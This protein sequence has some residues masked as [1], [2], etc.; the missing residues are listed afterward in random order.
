MI[1]INNTSINPSDVIWNGT[2]L[3]RL[4]F[5][6]VTVWEKTPSGGC[7]DRY[8]SFA[9]NGDKATLRI[10]GIDEEFT[11]TDNR[12]DGNITNYPLV[13]TDN[14]FTENSYT[15]WNYVGFT[16]ID[17][18]PCTDRVTT[19]KYMF[20]KPQGANGSNRIQSINATK[21]M[22]TS[23]CTNMH[24]M[25]YG[26]DH[27]KSLDLT[28]F[29]TSKV[30]DMGGMFYDCIYLPTIDGIE[31]FNTSGVTDMSYMFN[32]CLRLTELNIGSWDVSNV[33]DTSHMFGW[34][35]LDTI[36]LTNWN[37]INCTN[38]SYM[39]QFSDL[40]T[41]ALPLNTNV[42]INGEGLFKNCDKL[43]NVGLD[44]S[45]FKNC[46]HMFYNCKSLGGIPSFNPPYGATDCSYMFA[47][48]TNM[49][50]EEFRYWNYGFANC[51]NFEGM[52]QGCSQPIQKLE[53]NSVGLDS[54]NA[55]NVS[56][57]FDG[58]G[59]ME[60]NLM[61]ADFSNVEE[62]I[63]MFRN[64]PNLRTID[65]SGCNFATINLLKKK[66]PSG[67]TIIG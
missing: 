46:S 11:L 14:M 50:F 32:A 64:C 48:C 66:A 4:Q 35:P 38:W 36:D 3:S 29:D 7:T 25:F 51:E 2:S 59:A 60:I 15:S 1:E 42:D 33:T 45:L 26:C 34:F 24:G 41:I 13:R 31:N 61:G 27:L 18:V 12:Y 57:M 40:V 47:H 56:Y 54:G 9:Y 20:G 19:M 52:F 63:N 67:V 21:M 28:S 23:S 44:L 37:L 30:T 10:N 62:D 58:C 55:R 8:I 39:F 5:N 6:G 49:G 65:A 53:L 22:D 16:E 17:A 43:Q